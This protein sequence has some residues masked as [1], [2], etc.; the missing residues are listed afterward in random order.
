MERVE[1]DRLL[2]SRLPAICPLDWWLWDLCRLCAFF[3]AAAALLTA[4]I[5]TVFLSLP[6]RAVLDSVFTGGLI[7]TSGSA[8]LHETASSA[9]AREAGLVALESANA[10]CLPL[11]ASVLSDA[12]DCVDHVSGSCSSCLLNGMMGSTVT[13]CA[14]LCTLVTPFP[15]LCTEP[16]SCKRARF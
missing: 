2:F 10:S 15:S 16:V 1:P 7:E 5:E 13:G 14:F 11:C 12:F 8:V 3:W 4:C 6:F 9:A